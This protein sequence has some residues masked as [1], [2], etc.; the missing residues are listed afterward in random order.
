MNTPVDINVLR[1]LYNQGLT[2]KQVGQRVG[3]TTQAVHSRFQK[4][5]I[6]RRDRS[7]AHHKVDLKLLKQLIQDEG[8]SKEEAAKRLNVPYCVVLRAAKENGIKRGYWSQKH[9][10]LNNIK[11]GDSIVIP[12]RESKFSNY[13]PFYNIGRKL[14]IKLSVS[15]IDDQTVRVTRVA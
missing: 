12:R 15:S 14:G 3:I 11:V 8:L 5:G 2:L 7:N 9:P 1:D 4:A 13:T 6:P 10:G